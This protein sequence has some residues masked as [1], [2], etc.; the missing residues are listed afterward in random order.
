[1]T[2]RP[3]D[4]LTAIVTGGAE[5]IGRN[6]CH[7]LARYGANVVVADL[8][9]GDNIVA[10]LTAAGANAISVPT[11]VSD[12]AATV[13]MADQTIEAFGRIDILINNAG[14]FKTAFRGRFE[15]ISIDEWDKA[16][17]V[18]TRGPWLCCKAVVPQMRSQGS[19]KIINISSNTVNRGVPRFLH[20]VSSKSALTGLTRSLASELGGDNICVNTLSPD[21]IADDYL[22]DLEPGREEE[23]AAQRPIARPQS[24]EDMEGAMLFLAGPGSDFITGQ[25]LLVNGGMFF[26]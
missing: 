6:Y 5:G 26:H 10:E 2:D 3:L 12:E 13:N 22:R 25:T 1:V 8:L 7:A 17:A 4:G 24:A 11:D 16:F 9:P 18:N 20:Y 14:Y 23:I 21:F 15:D 19:G